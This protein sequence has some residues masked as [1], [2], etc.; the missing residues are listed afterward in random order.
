MA[1]SLM[2]ISS[3]AALAMMFFCFAGSGPIT[4]AGSP[5]DDEELAA[6]GKALFLEVFR[7]RVTGVHAPRG[8]K[9]EPHR[10]HEAAAGRRRQAQ[11]M[12]VG[13]RE[14]V[15]GRESRREPYVERHFRRGDHRRDASQHFTFGDEPARAA[16]PPGD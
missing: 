9:L 6:K 13:A 10:D 8:G 3:A 7:P 12:P 1:H 14:V 11:P 2:R 15:R 4:A 5:A 16:V